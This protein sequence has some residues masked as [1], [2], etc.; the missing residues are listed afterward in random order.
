MMSAQGGRDRDHC[1]I[2]N[3][4]RIVNLLWRSLFSTVGSLGLGS[5]RN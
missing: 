2:V 5:G 4:L 3:I 1:A